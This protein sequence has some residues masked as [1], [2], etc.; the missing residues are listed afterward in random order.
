QLTVVNDELRARQK[1]L[2]KQLDGARTSLADMKKQSQAATNAV[3]D[4]QKAVETL[5]AR[6]AAEKRQAE[7]AR[8]L[9]QAQ[10]EAARARQAPNVA[11][12]GGGGG[13][14]SVAAPDEGPGQVIASGP[15]V[16][17]VQGPHSFRNDWGEPRGGG[18]RGHRGTDIFSPGGT[19][20][21]APTD[22]TVF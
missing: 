19:P 20:T 12:G 3:A 13:S 7:L 8:R 1:E 14:G 5:K 18:T 15:W 6:L 10:A 16:C 11:G 22:G 21:V 4:S 9:A 2:N 17:P